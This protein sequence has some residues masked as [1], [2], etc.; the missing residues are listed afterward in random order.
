MFLRLSVLW[1]VDGYDIFT[2]EGV[3]IVFGFTIEQVTDLL[4]DAGR[5]EK[6]PTTDPPFGLYVYIVHY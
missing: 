2:F 4:Q 6:I 3:L 5:R 1:K